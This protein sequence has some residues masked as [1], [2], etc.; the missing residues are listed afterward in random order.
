MA[1]RPKQQRDTLD[2]TRAIKRPIVAVQTATTNKRKRCKKVSIP[3]V[4]QLIAINN[5]NTAKLI[6]CG[7]FTY[8][9]YSMPQNGIS[10]AAGLWSIAIAMSNVIKTPIMQRFL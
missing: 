3:A 6:Y 1:L 10:I 5:R 4:I 2:Q 8:I 7:G 9:L